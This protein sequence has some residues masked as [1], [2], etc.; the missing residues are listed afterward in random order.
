[1]RS[2]QIA[3]RMSVLAALSAMSVAISVLAILPMRSAGQSFSRV[4]PSI[5]WSNP[6]HAYIIWVKPQTMDYEVNEI[7]L[8]TGQSET[9]AGPK[10]AFCS[11][12]GLAIGPRGDLYVAGHFFGH[13]CGAAIEIF[14]RGAHGNVSPIAA[15]HGSR[16]DIHNPTGIGFDAQGRLYV[17]EENKDPSGSGDVKVFAA[18]V[19]GNVAPMAIISGSNTQLGRTPF[20]VAVDTKGDIF[21]AQGLPNGDQIFK[22]PANANG[23]VSPIACLGGFHG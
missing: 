20:G 6:H 19:S 4:S 5:A 9:L 22:Y 16:A 2:F 18:G 3:K 21:V 1:M 14:A 11:L 8:G 17:T 15:I 23:N 7:S 13:P 12:S 10:T